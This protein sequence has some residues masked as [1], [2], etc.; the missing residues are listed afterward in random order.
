MAKLYTKEQFW[1][2]Y[3]K[4]PQELKDALFAEETGDNI[5][6]T[7]K[8]NDIEESLGT[9]VDYVGAVL[10]GLLPPEDF[11]EVLEKE[12]TI[13]K[14]KAKRITQEINRLIFYPVKSDLEQLYRPEITPVE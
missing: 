8:R 12:L 9:I 1:K 11:Q 2:I 14:D 7:C 10:I 5:Y 6:E 3:Q 4:L 13:T